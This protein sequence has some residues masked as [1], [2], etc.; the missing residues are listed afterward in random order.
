MNRSID[1][2]NE[3]ETI[4]P[5]V[6]AIGNRNV[7]I[8]PDGYF[9]TVP[10]TVLATVKNELVA[11]GEAPEGY[12]DALSNTILSKIEGTA[13]NELQQL[14]P[15]LSG[16][17]KVNPF[18]VPE[19]YFEKAGDEI[20]F[21]VAGDIIPSVIQTINKDQPFEV[22]AGYFEQLPDRILNKVK[23]Q[24]EAKVIAMP[25]RS[26]SIWKY[27]A[28]A[29]FTGVMIFGV[30][31]FTGNTNKG[32]ETADPVM[33]AAAFTQSLENLPEE[34]IIKY[35]ERNGTQEDIAALTSSID[36]ADLPDQE[37][38]FID[39]ATLDKFLEEIELKN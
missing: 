24:G 10:V 4:S 20:T 17:K 33:T 18:E 35:L 8:V 23:V 25:R 39:N 6:A 15:L 2:L 12:F 7:F 9:E 16:I 29:V 21:Q 36:E 3:V 28:A 34:D 19:N 27:A 38:Y 31:K 1:I 22:P 11:A 30:Y 5:A 37:E 32:G 26:N 13:A 14:S